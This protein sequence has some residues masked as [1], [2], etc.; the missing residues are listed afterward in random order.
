[1]QDGKIR[2]LGY[3]IEARRLINSLLVD[4]ED[5]HHENREGIETDWL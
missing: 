2:E 1:V 5:T 3:I 4:K